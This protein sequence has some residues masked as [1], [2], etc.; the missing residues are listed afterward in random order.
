M[1]KRDPNFPMQG[2]GGGMGGKYARKAENLTAKELKAAGAAKAAKKRTVSISDTKRVTSG[3]NKGKTVGPGGKPLTGSVRLENGA[4][5]VYKDGKRVTK[6]PAKKAAP[7]TRSRSGSSSSSSSSSSRTAP[8][9]GQSARERRIAQNTKSGTT[10]ATIRV[11]AKGKNYNRY[12]PSTGKWE[13]VTSAAPS[14]VTVK[15]A[16]QSS[17]TAQSGTVSSAIAQGRAAGPGSGNGQKAGS[18]QGKVRGN[19]YAQQAAVRKAR[20]GR[21]TPGTA[22]AQTANRRAQDQ[23]N[24]ARDAAAIAG[25]TVGAAAAGAGLAARG[26]A[27]AA[28][29]ARAALPAGR[30]AL[31]PGRTAPTRVTVERMGPG[32]RGNAGSV[33]GARGAVS[34]GRP[35]AARGTAAAAARGSRGTAPRAQAATPNS[36]AAIPAGRNVEPLA[37][38]AAGRTRTSPVGNPR[39]NGEK[40]TGPKTLAQVRSERARKAAATRKANAAKKK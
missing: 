29:A 37:S 35:G 39:L 40:N 32:V 10:S 6:A 1:A 4:M 14:K 36:R 22:Q 2:K 28:Q 26:G 9:K 27:A 16:T 5:A 8:S 19:P 11:G 34:A 38:K 33:A 15:P 18:M 21:S 7:A 31:P 13:R 25:L 17:R 24:Q 23:R 30:R 20:T 12:N 3:A